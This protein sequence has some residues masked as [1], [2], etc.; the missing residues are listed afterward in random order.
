MDRQDYFT[1]EQGLLGDK[2]T[3]RSIC[4]DP[5][6]KTK[7]SACKAQGQVSQTTYKWLHPTCAIPTK[8][9]GLPAVFNHW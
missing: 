1:K 8:F 3:Y 5:L 7:K 6:L 2:D 4:K 9:Y